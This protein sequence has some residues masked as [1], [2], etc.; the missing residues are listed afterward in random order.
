MWGTKMRKVSKLKKGKKSGVGVEMRVGRKTLKFVVHE[1]GKVTG[2][3]DALINEA[4]L[5]IETFRDALI[6]I[7]KTGGTCW[8]KKRECNDPQEVAARALKK[9]CPGLFKKIDATPWQKVKVYK[10]GRV[11]WNKET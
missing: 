10:S 2:D 6:N 1:S 11:R 3:Y 9:R 4:I 7:M 5:T 8:D